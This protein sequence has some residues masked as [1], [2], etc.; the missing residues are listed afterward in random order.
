[1]LHCHFRDLHPKDTGEIL[2]EGTFP[3]CKHCTTQCNLWYS[4]HI[5]TQVCLLGAEQWTQRDSAITMALA[6]HKLCHIEGELLEKVDSF[7]YL[8]RILVQDDDDVRAVRNQIK[9]ARG[10]WARVGQVLTVD[11]TPPKVSAKF[12]MA[13][14]QSVLLYGSKIWNLSTTTLAWLEGFHICTAYQ[15]AK[16]HKP[17][18]GPHHG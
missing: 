9:K 1:M 5:H 8:G 16:K 10:I 13:V 12:Y 2:R 11:N 18:K 15:M 7:R 6:F 3:Q 14:V 4:W 17:K